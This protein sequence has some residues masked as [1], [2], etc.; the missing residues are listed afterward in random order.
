MTIKELLTQLEEIREVIAWND[1]EDCD[2][3]DKTREKVMIDIDAIV[4]TLNEN[5]EQ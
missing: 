1:V 5:E 2:L 4:E 3:T